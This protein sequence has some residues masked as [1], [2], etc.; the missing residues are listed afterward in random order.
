VRHS[1]YVAILIQLVDFGGNVEV[2]A[3]AVI[4]LLAFSALLRWGSRKMGWPRVR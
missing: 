2:P 3:G 4:K 1:T